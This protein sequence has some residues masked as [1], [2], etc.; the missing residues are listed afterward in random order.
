MV[1]RDVWFATTLVGGSAVLLSYWGTKPTALDALGRVG[2][3][4]APSLDPVRRADGP[5]VPVHPGRAVSDSP[6]PLWWSARRVLGQRRAV[7]G[8][9]DRGL[10]RS[11]L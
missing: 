1:P 11:T 7:D 8:A 5:G 9:D 2:R 3:G 6:Q 10:A 4:H